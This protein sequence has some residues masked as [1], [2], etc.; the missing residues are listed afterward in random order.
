LKAQAKKKIKKQAKMQAGRKSTEKSDGYETTNIDKLISSKNEDANASTRPGKKTKVPTKLT[1]YMDIIKP[2][3]NS[4]R[5]A[6][7]QSERPILL[8]SQDHS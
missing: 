1:A 7:H 8:H 5:E 2:P 3:P 6:N 4:E